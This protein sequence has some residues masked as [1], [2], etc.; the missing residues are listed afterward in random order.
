MSVIFYERPCTLI[1]E[2]IALPLAYFIVDHK[3][4][5]FLKSDTISIVIIS[6]MS[7]LSKNLET[8]NYYMQQVD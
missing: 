4:S 2:K 6:L 8:K 3:A 7:I 5:R 1:K